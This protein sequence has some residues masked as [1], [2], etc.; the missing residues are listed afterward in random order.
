MLTKPHEP[1]RYIFDPLD[2]ISLISGYRPVVIFSRIP[3]S[4][5]LLPNELLLLVSEGLEKCRDINVFSRTTAR[6]YLLFNRHLY[7]NAPSKD[8][9]LVPFRAALH[10]HAR[11][12]QLLLDYGIG[13]DSICLIRP[14]CRMLRHAH[15]T[16]AVLQDARIRCSPPCHRRILDT[17]WDYSTPASY[18]ST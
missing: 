4:L 3:R 11:T 1:G 7:L 14:L 2:N 13:A 18:R 6:L 16:W 8:C 17:A 10:G 5:L 15:G 12:A 9:V